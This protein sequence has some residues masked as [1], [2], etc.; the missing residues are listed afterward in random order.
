M[1]QH[2]IFVPGEKDPRPAWHAPE[3]D[4]IDLKCTLI[5]AGSTFDGYGPGFTE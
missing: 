5:S 2:M 4:T 1:E 3:I